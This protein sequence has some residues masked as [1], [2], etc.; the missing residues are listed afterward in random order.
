MRYWL[1]EKIEQRADPFIRLNM[2]NNLCSVFYYAHI[3][4]EFGQLCIIK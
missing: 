2:E 3:S 1:N 4:R